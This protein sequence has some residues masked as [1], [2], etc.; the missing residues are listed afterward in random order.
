MIWFEPRSLSSLS[1]V[2]VRVSVV[3]KQLLVTVTDVMAIMSL[4]I[5]LMGQTV[6]LLAVKTRN[7]SI[8]NES[9][10]PI[11]W[12]FNWPISFITRDIKQ[13][14]DDTIWPWRLPPLRL[15][16]RQSLLPITLTRNTCTLTGT[17]TLNKNH[18][19]IFGHRTSV[20]SHTFTVIYGFLPRKQD[21]TR[22]R[23]K[24][25]FLP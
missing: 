23:E 9:S 14:T 20:F 22:N 1:S 17:T 7:S 21:G 2:I 12:Q 25:C 19:Q 10:Q 18:Y 5:D 8:F 24:A 13:S 3:L 11:T 15:P 4:V 16:R 6:M